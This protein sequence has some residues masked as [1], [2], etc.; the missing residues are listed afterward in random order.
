MKRNDENLTRDIYVRIYPGT[1]SSR[2]ANIR[3]H[4]PSDPCS[5][6]IQ[7]KTGEHTVGSPDVLLDAMQDF[8]D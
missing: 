2:I 6:A 5:R 3:S 1:F 8:C 4:Q 7:Y